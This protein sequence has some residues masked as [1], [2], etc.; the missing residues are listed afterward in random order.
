MCNLWSKFNQ[1]DHGL[2][3]TR[4]IKWDGGSTK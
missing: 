4:H 1:F 3:K 2:I